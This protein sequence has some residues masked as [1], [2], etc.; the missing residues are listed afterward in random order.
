MPTND[1]DITKQTAG[2]RIFQFLMNTAVH[3]V[4]RPKII[5]TDKSMKKRS[6]GE[7]YIFVCNHTNH[8]DG[9]CVAAAMGKYKPYALVSRKWYDK[10]FYGSMIRLTRSIPINLDELD[11][12]WY[13]IGEEILRSGESM[14]IFPEGAIAREGRML[15]FKPG[16]GL[17]S[18]KTGV[19]VVPVASY[20][21]YKKFFGKRQKIIIGTPIKSECPP[22]V[23]FSKYS[24]KLMEES[25]AEVRKLYGSLEKKYGRTPVYFDESF[26]DDN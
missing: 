24:K 6:K 3:I 9:V 2:K 22:D 18:A 19:S 12:S 25:E 8:M 21:V 7:N 17:L 16:A 14:L 23:R 1:T 11:A 10:K 13:H 15:G 5:Y 4:L 20:G 26:S